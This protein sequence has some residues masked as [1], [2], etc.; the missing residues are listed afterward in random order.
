MTMLP[1][2]FIS[3]YRKLQSGFGFFLLV[4]AIFL[5]TNSTPLHGNEK[6]K[7]L[8]SSC[9]QISGNGVEGVFPP[10]VG[11]ANRLASTKEGREYLIQVVSFG[12]NEEIEV[13]GVSYIGYMPPNPQLTNLEIANLLNYILKDLSKDPSVSTF[14]ESE[15]ELVRSIKRTMKQVKMSRNQALSSLR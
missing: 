4:F 8:C 2:V 11:W 5:L 13:N 9:H 1:V 6:Y 14:T 7:S 10:L 12:L 3:K 15:V